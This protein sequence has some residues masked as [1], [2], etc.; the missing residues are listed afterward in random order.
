[1]SP[2]A[3]RNRGPIGEVVKSYIDTSSK[4]IRR[5][6]EVASGSGL[7]VQHLA[8]L[9][10]HVTWQPSE[11]EESLLPAI[12][13]NTQYCDNVLE[14]MLLDI[15]D[16]VVQSDGGPF[17]NKCMDAI[18]NINMMHISPLC[19]SEKLFMAST[20]LLRPGGLLFTYGPFAENGRLEPESNRQFD[21]MLRDQNPDWGIR[22]L[23]VLKQFSMNTFVVMKEIH[24]MPANNLLVVWENKQSV[25]SLA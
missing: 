8:K 12:R 23:D 7:H 18:L 3:E 16:P 2:A 4:P 22:D 24:R 21:Q 5:V 19:T 14:P 20:Q 25:A 13:S 17:G 9:M 1:M 10:P 11:C 15:T 6:L